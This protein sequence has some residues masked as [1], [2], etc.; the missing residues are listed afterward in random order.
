MTKSKIQ[1]YII[2]LIKQK[3]PTFELERLDINYIEAGLIDSLGIIELVE[4]IEMHFS[5]A[6]TPEDFHNREFQ[7]II[8][9]VN[10]VS[11]KVTPNEFSL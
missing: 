11:L 8:G 10:I 9:L 5:I 6:F 1:E 7:T 4:E 3:N 2:E